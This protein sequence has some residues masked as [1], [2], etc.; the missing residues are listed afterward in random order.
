MK[1]GKIAVIGVGAVGSA[2]AFAL[3]LE[4]IGNQIVVVD[5]DQQ[6]AE[7][8]TLDLQDATNISYNKKV[9]KGNPE[10]ARDAQI[11]V[12]AAGTAQRPGE[13]RL[14]LL[15]RNRK[16]LQDVLESLHPI[17]PKS[18]LL[19][20]SN[21]VDILTLYA[22][23]H[24]NLPRN[25]VFGS[26]TYLD[27]CRLRV[28]IAEQAKVSESSVHAYVLGEHGDSQFAAFSCATIGG[29]PIR[30][31]QVVG[32]EENLTALEQATRHKAAMIIQRKRFTAWGIASCV[33]SI[34]KD[35]VFNTK[36]VMPLSVYSS[37]MGVCLS[38]P[39]VLG[40]QGIEQTSVNIILDKSETAKLA[41]SAGI[42]HKLSVQL[43]EKS[44]I[45]SKL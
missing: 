10:D 44:S 22:Q 39:V 18:I 45:T 14:D 7:G 15:S 4:N 17:D 41:R 33:S 8:E 3:L 30:K 40:A 19:I 25:Q 27:T 28:A 11:I 34:C 23:N 37:E 2:I 12:M 20:V 42:L 1:E 31:I 29:V 24:S 35:I 43:E 5:S 36:T 13:T 26:G 32:N 16:I 38:V 9:F 21:P 6:R